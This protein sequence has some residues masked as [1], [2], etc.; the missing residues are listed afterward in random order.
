MG[1][2]LIVVSGPSGTGKTTLAH[3]LAAAIG[4]P[5]ICR[6]EIKEGMVHALGGEFTPAPGDPLT[7]RTFSVFFEVVR[8]LLEAGA[9]VV[10]EAAFEDQV[11]RSQLEPLAH[12]ARV[13]ILRCRLE[14]DEARRRMAGR[15][16]RTAHVDPSALETDYHRKFALLS[17]AEPT[18]D[19]D[20]LSGYVPSLDEI[21]AFVT[22][23]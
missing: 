12:L 9:T 23:A 13:R 7:R 21:V 6:D 8:L 10:A 4:C 3:A 20:T 11:W 15:P 18:L 17:L 2:V 16:T 14:P 22:G 5:A 1:P 19:V